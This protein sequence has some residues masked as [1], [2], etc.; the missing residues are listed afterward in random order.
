M[1]ED[2]LPELS[3]PHATTSGSNPEELFG[4][5]ERCLGQ[6]QT[7]AAVAPVPVS[8]DPS[9]WSSPGASSLRQRMNRHFQG[10]SFKVS[11]WMDPVLVS[12]SCRAPAKAIPLQLSWSCEQGRFSMGIPPGPTGSEVPNPPGLPALP[13]TQRGAFQ[14][15]FQRRGLSWKGTELLII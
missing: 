2:L 8:P 1:K 15:I 9:E 11:P 4:S 7:A 14:G 6:V 3:I 13:V 5:A 10:H 12:V